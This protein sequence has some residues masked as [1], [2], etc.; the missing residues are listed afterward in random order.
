MMK[1]IYA[2]FLGMLEFRSSFT[3]GF[4]FPLDHTYDRGRDFAHV[5][6]LRRFEH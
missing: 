5:I 2:F 6:T 3:T 4:T 1:H